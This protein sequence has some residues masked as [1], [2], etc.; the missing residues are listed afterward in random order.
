MSSWLTQFGHGQ[1]LGALDEVALVLQGR[2]LLESRHDAIEGLLH[3]LVVGPQGGI[4]GGVAEGMERDGARAQALGA[5]HHRYAFETGTHPTGG[6][7]AALA[8]T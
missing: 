5:A 2:Q 1:L 7:A 4:G 8:W 3:P 6:T